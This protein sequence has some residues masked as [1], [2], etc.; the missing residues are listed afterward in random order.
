LLCNNLYRHLLLYSSAIIP[1]DR[2]SRN[3][4]R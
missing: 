3:N 1:A 4:A 2:F